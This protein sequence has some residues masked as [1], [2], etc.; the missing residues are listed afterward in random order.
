MP[1]FLADPAMPAPL[2]LSMIDASVLT[3]APDRL[4]T[5]AADLLLSGDTARG[6]Q[7]LDLLEAR[8]AADP[9]RVEAGGRFMA[10]QSFRYA[11]MGQAEQAV[12]AALAARSIKEQMQL[13]DEWNVAAP[14]I[15]PTAYSW[16][17]DYPAVEREA[18]AALATPELTEPVKLVMMPG[19]LALAWFEVRP[20]EPRP[21]IQPG[22]PMREA[23]RLGF[24][25][26]SSPS[27]TC[28]RWPAWRWNGETSTQPSSSPSRR[29]R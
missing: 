3:D 17:E 11:L 28:A 18:A 14:M 4:L 8:S 10:F 26:T 27:T 7:Y 12:S 19:V 2:D 6:S 25:G 29:C 21:P 22:P 23:R 5:V 20:P 13:T 24:D 15:L 9:P 16:L 1:D